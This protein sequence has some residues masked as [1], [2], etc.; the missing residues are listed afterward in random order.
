LHFQ[1]FVSTA[2]PTTNFVVV[3]IDERSN[4]IDTRHTEVGGHPKSGTDV[5]RQGRF[6]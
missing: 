5:T 2:G 1:V 6:N 3:R 4:E